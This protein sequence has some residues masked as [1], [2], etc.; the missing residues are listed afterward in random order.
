MGNSNH[1]II[2][3]RYKQLTN[4]CNY[5][6]LKLV[7]FY[8]EPN[9]KTRTSFLASLERTYDSANLFLHINT[10]Q[11]VNKELREVL[12][13][14]TFEVDT[15]R[16]LKEQHY[17]KEF[18]DE[19]SKALR[20]IDSICFKAG[21]IYDQF[22][23]LFSSTFNKLIK[24]AYLHVKAYCERLYELAKTIK[25]EFWHKIATSFLPK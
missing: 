5:T 15:L 10:N 1:K 25:Y 9:V 24:F 7:N 18:F 17:D 16:K 4:D 19:C 2:Q 8:R 20:S 11:G 21:H 23:S 12:L 3:E 14:L 6:F 22:P 13:T